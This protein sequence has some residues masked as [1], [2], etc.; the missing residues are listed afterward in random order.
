MGWNELQNELEA[1]GNGVKRLDFK[2][3]YKAVV[4]DMRSICQNANQP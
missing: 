2:G 1:E 4:N 3:A